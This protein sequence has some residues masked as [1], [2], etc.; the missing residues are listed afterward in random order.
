MD[1]K[2][3]YHKWINSP[4]FDEET[5]KELKS[6]TDEKEIEDRFYKHLSFG[7]GGLRGVIG[8]GTN[9]MN[10]YTVGKATQGL[11]NFINKNYKEK[12]VVIAYDSRRMSKEFALSCAVILCANGIKAYLFDGLRPTPELSFAV[13]YYGATAGI[14]I[15]ASH[16]PPEYNGYKV[17]LSDGGQIVPPYDRL[18]IEEVNKIEDYSLI[19]RTDEKSAIASGLL[20]IISKEADDAFIN[21]VKSLSLNP[22]VIRKQADNDK[23]AYTPLNGA[24]NMPVRRVLSEEGFKNVYV[25][26]EQEA[27]DGNF[28]TLKYPNPEDPAAFDYCLK[29]AEKVKADIA[30]ATDPDADRLGIYAFDNKSGEYKSFTGNM[31][32]LL[33]AEY[34]LS[35]KKEKGLL[36]ENPKDGVLVTTVVSSKMAYKIAEFYGISVKEVLTGFKYIGEQIHLYELAKAKNGGKYDGDKGAYEYLFGYEESFGCLVGTHARDKD[37]VSA[38]AML[39]EACAYYKDRGLTLCDQ[40][41]N[42]YRKYGY[43]KESMQTVTLKGVAGAEKIRAIM[44]NLRNAPPKNI[45]KSKVLAIRDYLLDKRVVLSDGNALKTGLPKSNVLYYELENDGWCCVRP[46]GTEPKIKFYYGVKAAS[47]KAAAENL[48]ELG[49]SI[50]AF[51]D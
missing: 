43:F 50:S 48:S 32:G 9:R 19:R 25:V 45:G 36:P 38:V 17:Y 40:M 24:G 41:E 34:I 49:K 21:A 27:A 4:V 23:I 42:I 12:S 51:T 39:A 46:S 7:T 31:S 26:S 11:A 1:Y 47:E 44:D 22:S 28:P 30:L 6:L 3:E 20:Q 33:I 18:I 5:K 37:S 15:T 13:R 29:L 8:A 35:Q 2:A 10:V 14:V 16:N